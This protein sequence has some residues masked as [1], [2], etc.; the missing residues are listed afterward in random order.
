MAIIYN[1][2]PVLVINMNVCKISV[3]C[4]FGIIYTF[5]VKLIEKLMQIFKH[6]RHHSMYGCKITDITLSN[7]QISNKNSKISNSE[8]KW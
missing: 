6:F 2:S 7:S 5:W 4:E 1:G 8:L 3:K